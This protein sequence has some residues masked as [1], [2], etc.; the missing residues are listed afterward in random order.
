[1][2]GMPT[3]DPEIAKNYGEFVLYH[4]QSGYNR[5]FLDV[6]KLMFINANLGVPSFKALLFFLV[7]VLPISG[8]CFIC[9]PAKWYIS[10]E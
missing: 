9:I 1:M 10:L 3:Q 6:T 4:N 7:P 8:Q 5:L 2:S